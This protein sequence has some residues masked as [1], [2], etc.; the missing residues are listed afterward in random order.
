MRTLC[1]MIAAVGAILALAAFVGMSLV[2]AGSTPVE[3]R[4]VL[5]ALWLSFSGAHL[6]LHQGTRFRSLAPLGALIGGVGILI[7]FVSASTW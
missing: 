1:S 3:T 5:L 7:L 6:M 4:S 2:S